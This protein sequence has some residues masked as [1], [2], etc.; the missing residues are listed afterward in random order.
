MCVVLISNTATDYVL[1]LSLPLRPKVK[2][3]FPQ[4]F[5]RQT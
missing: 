5:V 2:P 1:N 3:E 4:L